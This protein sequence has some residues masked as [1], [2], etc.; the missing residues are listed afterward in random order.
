MWRARIKTKR[1]RI[2]VGVVSAVYVMEGGITLWLYL[3]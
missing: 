1:A 3:C 2:I